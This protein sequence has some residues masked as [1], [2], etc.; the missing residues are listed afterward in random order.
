CQNGEAGSAEPGVG[1][2]PKGAR[3]EPQQGEGDGRFHGR[4]GGQPHL[5]P[6]GLAGQPP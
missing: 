2:A 4:A 1:G 6:A 5:P 3:G